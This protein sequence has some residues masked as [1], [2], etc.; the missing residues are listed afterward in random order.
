MADD[1]GLTDDA[2]LGGRLN[3]LQPRRGFRAGIDSV[4]LAAAV[5][6][7]PGQRVFEAGT[8]PGVAALCLAAR[9]PDLRIHGVEHDAAA[10]RLAQENA[11]RNRL[12]ENLRI[13]CADVR[14]VPGA[15]LA[16]LAQNSFH[17][18]FANPPYF[19]SGRVVPPASPRR[20]VAHVFAAEDGIDAWLRALTAMVAH[21]GTVSVIHPASALEPLLTAFCRRLGDVR[22]APLFPRAG[23]PASRV[24]V[25][26]VKGS[27]AP[28]AL[29]PGI[30]LHRA[31]GG[32]TAEAEAVL[33]HGSA[34]PLR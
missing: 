23:A 6:A 15:G 4:F 16:G 27:R 21:R 3:I 8:G 2:F 22:A 12:R 11:S 29:L 26:G 17:H 18:A 10:A 33:R 28:L 24:I 25:Q 9:V 31:D 5:P 1:E 14:K 32:F 30:V 20:A 7:R 34:F 13:T 19:A